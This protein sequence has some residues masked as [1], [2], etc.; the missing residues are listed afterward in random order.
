MITARPQKNLVRAK[1]YFR[2]HL[3]HGNYY[4]EG[5]KVAGVQFG[6][7]AVR[8]G[9][10]PGQP[11]TA[12]ADARLGDNLHPVTG[13]RLTVRQRKVDRRVFHDFVVAPPKSVSVL[14]LVV[15]NTRIL[16]ANLASS[17]VALREMERV[18]WFKLRRLVVR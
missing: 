2:E 9:L 13:A 15:G 10:D 6:Q 4:S 11:V 7:G 18:R 16:E 5:Q 3:A 1:A 14:A 17:E 12:Q 8:L